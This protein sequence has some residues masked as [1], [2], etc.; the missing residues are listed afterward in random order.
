MSFFLA[1]CIKKT[2]APQRENTNAACNLEAFDYLCSVIVQLPN[3]DNKKYRK[4]KIEKHT[5]DKQVNVHIRSNDFDL[6]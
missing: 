1:K 5:E 6:L 4:V 2:N 3:A